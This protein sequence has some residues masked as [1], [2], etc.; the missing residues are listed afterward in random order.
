[1]IKRADVVIIGG[2]VQGCSIAYNLAKKGC[3]NIVVLEKNTCASG[4]S[5]RCSAGI[6]QQ[7]GTELSCILAHESVRIFENL[8]QELDYDIGLDQ[9]G[10]LLLAYNEKEVDQFKK[11]IALQQSLG[12]NARFL[13]VEG[14]K[15]VSPPIDV[16]G[17]LAAAF[18]P[19]DGFADPMLT[20]FAY[21]EAG[22]RLGV[23]IYRYT[24]AISIEV[25]K[26]CILSVTTDKGKILTSV[27]VNAAGGDAGLIGKMV[28][29]DIPVYFERHQILITE[30]IDHLIG[31]ALMSFSRNYFCLQQ[32]HGSI[33]L[34]FG[35]TNE[36]RDGDISATWQ[37]ARIMAQKIVA[38][39][40]L[41]KNVRVVRQWGG[42]YCISPDHQPILG[43]HPQIDGF[44]MSVGFSGH[45]FMNAPITGQLISE[46][47]LDG[48]T[49][50]PIDK[51]DIGRFERGE[52]IHEPTAM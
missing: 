51:L 29:I 20:T 6:R 13:T 18:C 38:V 11:N 15:K 7:F 26:G 39:V 2:G 49:S 33:S 48:K 9:C 43:T 19:T 47:I 37:F 46:L 17:V 28:G 50:I 41:L 12:I 35:E 4:S 22:Q 8:S 34:A 45:G 10:Y 14:A 36:R 16:D 52:L 27:V 42:L 1:M 21:A 30:P 44:Y 40:P 23:K 24:E 31:P 32:P 3:K 25:N 5:G